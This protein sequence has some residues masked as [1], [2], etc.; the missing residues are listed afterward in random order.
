MESLKQSLFLI[1][2]LI[3]I[4]FF[5]KAQDRNKLVPDAVLIQHAGSIG[6]LSAGVGYE[7]FKNNKGS[8]DLLYGYVSQTEGG[9]LDIATVKFS[10]RTFSIHIKDAAVIYPFNPGAFFSYTF[11]ENL[12]FAFD[13]QQYGKG[14]YGWSEAFRSHLSVSNELELNGS[15]LFGDQK[16]KAIVIYSEFN[17][18]D[19]YLVSWATNTDGLSL[20]DIFKFGVGVR[21]KF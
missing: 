18:N 14:Y 3:L 11:S 21:V 4:P 12:S 17:S 16:I 8:L 19:L 9:K 20:A 15:K 2:V 6:Y 7:L 10:Y 13:R 1:K 5:L